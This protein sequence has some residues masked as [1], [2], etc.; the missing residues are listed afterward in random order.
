MDIRSNDISSLVFRRKTMKGI[1]NISID[2]RSLAVLVEINGK[3]NMI[4]IAQKTGLTMAQLREVISS[5]LKQ[6]LI[7]A[8]PNGVKFLSKHFLES[9]ETELAIAVGPI[10]EVLVEDAMDDLGFADGRIP[11]AKAPELIELISRDI[12]RE[13]KKADFIKNMI[14]ILK[15]SDR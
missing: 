7:E 5:L 8:S 12:Q 6:N 13:E 2:V 15:S 9:L 4:S 11:Y 3:Q 10:A 14:D 1:G